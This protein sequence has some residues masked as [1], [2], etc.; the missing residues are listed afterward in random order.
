VTLRRRMARFTGADEPVMA[1][2]IALRPDVR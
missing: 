1:S 2:S